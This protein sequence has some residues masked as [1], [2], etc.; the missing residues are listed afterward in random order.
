M[1]LGGHSPNIPVFSSET[2]NLEKT[3]V[4]SQETKSVKYLTFISQPFDGGSNRILSIL[5]SN[6]SVFFYDMQTDALINKLTLELEIMRYE[7]SP[8]G[9]YLACIP[10]CGRVNFY[11][12]IQYVSPIIPAVKEMITEKSESKIKLS[13]KRSLPFLKEIQQQVDLSCLK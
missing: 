4:V 2:W 10:T 13:F 11:T 12:L 1:A 6:G 5:S 8:E 3:L 7:P 9:K